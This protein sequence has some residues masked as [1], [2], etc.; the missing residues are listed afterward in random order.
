MPMGLINAPATFMQ[1]INIL[2]SEMLDLFMAVFLDG[3]L[4]YS[5]MMKEHFILLKK[6][7][8][9]VGQY[10]CYC[11]LKNSSFSCNSTIFLSFDIIPEGMCIS[12]L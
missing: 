5:Y 4:M 11:K 1:T 2:F 8:V 12:D 9:H 3:I 6:V 7:L 10:I